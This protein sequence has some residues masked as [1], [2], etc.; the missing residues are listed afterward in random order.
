MTLREALDW[1]V[2]EAAQHWRIGHGPRWADSTGSDS[3]QTR[4]ELAPLHHYGE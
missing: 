4:E 1:A 3:G 2:I